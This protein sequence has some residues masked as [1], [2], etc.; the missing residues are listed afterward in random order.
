MGL[1][2]VVWAAIAG[3]VQHEMARARLSDRVD[4]VTGC[5][6]KMGKVGFACYRN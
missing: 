4:P 3:A 6:P 5:P 2:I 1:S